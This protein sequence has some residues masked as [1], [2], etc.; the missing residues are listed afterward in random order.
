MASEAIDVVERNNSDGA[1]RNPRDVSQDGLDLGVDA[2]RRCGLPT[3]EE[4]YSKL[5][6]C[7]DTIATRLRYDIYH[8]QV[9]HCTSVAAVV[10]QGG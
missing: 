1:E 6:I 4:E 7:R 8:R 2:L 5:L 9:V 10:N 3:V